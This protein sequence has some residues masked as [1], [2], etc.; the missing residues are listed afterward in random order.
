MDD[1]SD[2]LGTYPQMEFIITDGVDLNYLVQTKGQGGQ[3]RGATFRIHTR[4]WISDSLCAAGNVR[5]TDWMF[6]Y[7][8]SPAFHCLHQSSHHSCRQAAAANVMSATQRHVTHP[9]LAP[10]AGTAQAACKALRRA[11]T[12][13]VQAAPRHGPSWQVVMVGLEGQALARRWV[14]SEAQVCLQLTDVA[15]SWATLGTGSS[16]LAAYA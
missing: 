5:S 14:P 16:C 12:S 6:A 2:H 1:L 4:Q 11:P 10:S 3:A 9:C 13:R 15:R 8:H 7:G